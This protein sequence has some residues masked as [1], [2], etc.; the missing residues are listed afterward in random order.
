MLATYHDALDDAVDRLD[1]ACR[2]HEEA[3]ACYRRAARMP[4]ITS[5][6]FEACHDAPD[7]VCLEVN[8]K[9]AVRRLGRVV[10]RPFREAATLPP[11]PRRARRSRTMRWLWPQLSE[12][13]Q[14]LRKLREVIAKRLARATREAR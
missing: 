14:R 13:E 2:A 1:Q 10:P 9:Q 12:T 8:W 7:D 3:R 11:R 5:G 6:R 4:Q